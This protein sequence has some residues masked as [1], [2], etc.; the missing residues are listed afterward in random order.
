LPISSGV[1]LHLG[2]GAGNLLHRRGGVVGQLAALAPV[3]EHQPPR[4]DRG[5]Q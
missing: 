2:V 1:R 5:I 4:I 3:G